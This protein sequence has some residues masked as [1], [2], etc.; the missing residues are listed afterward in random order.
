MGTIVPRRYPSNRPPLTPALPLQPPNNELWSYERRPRLTLTPILFAI[1]LFAVPADVA[2][3]G[4]PSTASK[5]ASEA[6]PASGGTDSLWPTFASSGVV[7][8]ATPWD[9]WRTDLR[10]LFGTTAYCEAV[11]ARLTNLNTKYAGLDR[12]P[13]VKTFAEVFSARSMAVMATKNTALS[14]LIDLGPYVQETITELQEA[15]LEGRKPNIQPMPSML[16]ALKRG[17]Y[18]ATRQAAVTFVRWLMDCAVSIYCSG[19]TALRLLTD[20]RWS[21]EQIL[22]DM[23]NRLNRIGPIYITTLNAFQTWLAADFTVS[24]VLLTCRTVTMKDVPLRD[25]R[26]FWIQHA[27][28]QGAKCIVLW[29]VDP[30][31]AVIGGLI[32]NSYALVLLGH[33]CA[34]V[35]TFHYLDQAR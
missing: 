14:L 2:M 23:P 4:S 12:C 11:P 27:V 19:E 22:K 10:G 26:R 9:A 34:D 33:S 5:L 3:L 25:R 28:H 35:A 17:M 1:T 8:I 6:W 24:L 18:M 32:F 15:D 20:Y 31:G 13:R 21:I 30:I 29:V 7:V 16:P